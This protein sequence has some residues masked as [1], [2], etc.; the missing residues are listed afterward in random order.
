MNLTLDSSDSLDIQVCRPLC[1][2]V[3]NLG[4][5]ASGQVLMGTGFQ[6]LLMRLMGASCLVTLSSW[7]P[8]PSPGFKGSE[9][10]VDRHQSYKSIASGKSK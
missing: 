2:N 1:L 5:E 6:V 8:V 9:G 10:C 4:T 7:T 3:G